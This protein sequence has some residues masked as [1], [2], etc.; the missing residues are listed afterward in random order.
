MSQKRKKEKSGWHRRPRMSSYV[1]YLYKS[2]I[3]LL[4]IKEDHFEEEEDEDSILCIIFR[5]CFS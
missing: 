2:T 3:T 5:K 4:Y 1:M